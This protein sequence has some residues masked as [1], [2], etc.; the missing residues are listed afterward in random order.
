M[1]LKTIVVSG[2]YAFKACFW[3]IPSRKGHQPKPFFLIKKKTVY[4]SNITTFSR[5]NRTISANFLVGI[6]N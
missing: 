5:V 4:L 1:L 6:K 3:V 2:Y